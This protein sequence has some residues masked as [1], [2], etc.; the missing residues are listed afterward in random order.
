MGQSQALT[1]ALAA[2]KTDKR[3]GNAAA[4]I[5]AY[6][7]GK[8]LLRRDLTARQGRQRQNQGRMGRLQHHG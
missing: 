4:H 5:R 7:Q 2:Q 1:I 6:G 8:R 3:G